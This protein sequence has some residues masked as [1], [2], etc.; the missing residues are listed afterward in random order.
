MVKITELEGL[1]K[2]W[3]IK[4]STT[5]LKTAEKA[6]QQ[7]INLG[8]NTVTHVDSS[9]GS[10]QD[11]GSH[12]SEMWF[13]RVHTRTVLPKPAPHLQGWCSQEETRCGG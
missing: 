4:Q 9:G 11:S 10:R 7:S 5:E 13:Q 1:R 12:A 2:M 6:T 8:E 3:N